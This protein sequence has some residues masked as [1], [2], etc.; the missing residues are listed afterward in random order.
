MRTLLAICPSASD[1][2]S[3]YRGMGPLTALRV[4]GWQVEAAPPAID[5]TVLARADAVFMQRPSAPAYLQIFEMAKNLGRPVWV[6]Y[7]DDLTDVPPSNP[8]HQK[9]AVERGNVAVIAA[10]A[11]VVTTST[12]VLARRMSDLGARD[13]R[14]V[15]NA[16]DDRFFKNF[17]PA[18]P[19]EKLVFWRGSA[20]H[21]EDLDVHLG[22]IAEIHRAHPDWRWLFCGSPFWKVREVI[23]AAQLA[24][25]P[26]SRDPVDYLRRL[27]RLPAGVALVPLKDSPFNRAKS[28]I[29]WLEATYAGAAAVG[30][31]FPEWDRP[32]VTTYGAGVG[33]AE[34]FGRAAECYARNVAESRAYIQEHLLL[35][36]VNRLRAE[37]LGGLAS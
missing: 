13:V 32:G 17:A 24:V 6:D 31:D 14:V 2:T 28:N 37:I 18:R 33:L 34:A 23:A 22:G 27:E 29:A 21:D 20:T 26:V 4:P 9:Y 16:W 12:G 8:T 1:A 3:F 19:L 36:R 25:D 7:D 5:W 15:P 30:P 35:S 11:D 10:H